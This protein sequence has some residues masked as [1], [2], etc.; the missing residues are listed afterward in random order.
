MFELILSFMA[1]DTVK[2]INRNKD[3]KEKRK[4]LEQLRLRLNMPMT[5]NHTKHCLCRLCV[6]RRERATQDFNTL[7]GDL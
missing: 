6:N 4:R 3:Q 1:Y 5:R 7:L 2:T